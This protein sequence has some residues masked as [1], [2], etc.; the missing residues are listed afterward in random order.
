MNLSK[1]PFSKAILLAI[2]VGCFMLTL[3]LFDAS[4]ALAQVSEGL[5]T[6]R[7]TSGLVDTDLAELIGN[8][9]KVFLSVLGVIFLILVLYAGFVWMTSQGD[10]DKITKAK[11]IMI[12]ATIGLIITLSSY[13]I[14]SF[15]INALTGAISDSG[16]STS[17]SSMVSIERR[18]G[19]LGLG[20][21]SDHYPA[22]NATDV[23][24]NTNIFVT[25]KQAMDIE[26]FIDGYD[27]QGTPEDVSDDTVGTAL[28]TSNILI[29]PT[30]DGE[31]VALASSDVSV[32]FT[33]DL[34]TF[35]FDVPLLG[36]STEDM[37]YT[38]YL[39][40]SIT[41]ADGSSVLAQEGY[42]WSFEVGT[43]IDLTPPTVRTVTPVASGTYDRNIAVQITFSE[44][45]DPTSASG[46]RTT[47]AG[48][49]NIQTTGVS[50]TPTA[51]SY[52]ISN[53]YKTVTFV[54][55]DPCGTNSC[56][57]TIY[58]LPGSQTV[59]VTAVAPTIG[60]EPPQVDLSVFPY[61]GIVD[62]SGN[63][64]DGDGNGTAGDDYA[65][66]FTTTDDINLDG[67]A[68]TA[69]SPNILEED[70]ALDQEV[71]ITFDSIMMS[72]TLISSTATVNYIA[73]TPSPSHEMWFSIG[74][75]SL[76]A[77]GA[78]ASESKK[79]PV[80]TQ[81]RINHG[82]FLESVDGTAGEEG[83]TYYYITDVGEGVKNQYQNCFVPGEGIDASGADCGTSSEYPYCCNGAASA[84]ACP[85]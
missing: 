34:K 43:E 15:I 61:D 3:F 18:S 13:A 25:F 85:F 1:A 73:L 49:D 28:N 7:Q 60:S 2:G 47:D 81:A 72:S 23:A 67:P 16:A 24:R 69:I 42:E 71:L 20:G 12:N 56:G 9:I 40:G 51:G 8:I 53:Q 41:D 65:W 37:S 19:S 52:V 80:A 4:P 66:S 22:R 32:Y 26:S 30:E 58:C 27:T 45:V 82:V 59:A 33:D 57:E 5:E 68:I 36:S 55:D 10:P 70:V 39:D 44:A 75:T 83:Q 64:L 35:V 46:T 6:A 84:S 63:G 21:L 11:N 78:D 14:A 54:S 38:V 77:V 79:T 76:D 50:G 74:S 62:T 48:F 29:Y 31:G 17:S